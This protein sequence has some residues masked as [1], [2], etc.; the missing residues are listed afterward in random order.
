MLAGKTVLL[1]VSG[2]IAAYK[3][4]Y[5]ASALKK[6]KADVHVLMTRNATNFI[7]PITFE[8]LTG[9]KC[10]VDT[11]DR[12]FEFSVEHVSLAKAADV[13]LVAPASANV[14]AK[15]AHGLADDMLT[16]TVLACTCKKIISPAM[17]TRMFENPITQDNLKICEHYG[18]EVISPA[19][20]YLACGDTGAGK[21]PEPE[22]LLQYILKEV[23]YE[24]DLKGKK[25]LVTAGPTREA[26]DPVRYITNH[27]T[28]KMG[29]A[30]AKT[31]ALRG[32]DVT[33]VSGPAEVE[34]PMFVNFVPVVTAKDMFEAVTSR[35]DEMDAVIKAAAV[36]DYRPKF[37]NTEKTK[38]GDM[39]IELERT[40]DILKWLGEHKKDSQFLCGFS[41]ETEH[42]L[43]NSRAKLKKKNLDMIVA[44]NLKV[45]GAG[46]GTDTNVVTMIRENREI[47]LPIM[48]KEEVAGAILDEIFGIER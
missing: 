4:A 27:S 22:V 20:G 41:M 34:P 35:S 7:N 46:F 48:S 30:I 38:D 16:T 8:T 39:A 32:A 42:M 11:F 2:S 18:M 36:A 45:A 12:N 24:K 33:L 13:V 5:L 23:Q 47:E 14:I 26:I 29:Y 15:L 44:N 19:S 6:L 17:N 43:E 9:N 25:I 1:C 3:I 10:L 31:A 40:D 37:V 21:M 28:G